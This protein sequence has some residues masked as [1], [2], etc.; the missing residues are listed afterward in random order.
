LITFIDSENDVIQ[1]GNYEYGTT[2]EELIAIAPTL[3]KT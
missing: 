2:A 1:T 3:L